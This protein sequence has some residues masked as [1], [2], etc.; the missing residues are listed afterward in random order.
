MNLRGTAANSGFTLIEL[1]IALV[2][3]GLIV[4]GIL[5]GQDMIKAAEVR[6]QISQIEKYNQAV[7]TFKGKFGG[8]PGDL[9]MSTANQ[10]GFATDAATCSGGGQGRRDGNGLIDGYPGLP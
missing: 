7:N 6:A 3:I 10:F 5:V 9:A 4:G 8:L 2:I 1:S